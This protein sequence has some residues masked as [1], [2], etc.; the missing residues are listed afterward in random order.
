M[1]R[2]TALEAGT[3]ACSSRG[4]ILAADYALGMSESGAIVTGR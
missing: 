4:G 1:T 3:G 2:V